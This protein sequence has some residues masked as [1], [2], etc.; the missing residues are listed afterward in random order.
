VGTPAEC[1]SGSPGCSTRRRHGGRRWQG[2]C[3]AGAGR[4]TACAAGRGPVPTTRKRPSKP[5]SR[6]PQHQPQRPVR[7]TRPDAIADAVPR[8]GGGSGKPL[9]EGLLLRLYRRSVRRRLDQAHKL[10]GH[11]LLVET[12]SGRAYCRTKLLVKTPPEAGRIARSRWLPESAWRASIRR[13]SV[14]DRRFR[15]S[16]SR[17]KVSPDGNHAGSFPV[18]Q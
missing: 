13:R 17:R 9:T 2:R 3:A 15:L 1:A 10:R 6:L 11:F 7:P 8:N 16:L 18:L 5:V 14:A 12:S 4:W